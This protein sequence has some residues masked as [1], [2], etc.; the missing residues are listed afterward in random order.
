MSKAG[1]SQRLP[2][3]EPTPAT[4]EMSLPLL[5]EQNVDD[6]SKSCKWPDCNPLPGNT[7]VLDTMMS[8]SLVALDKRRGSSSDLP[9]KLRKLTTTDVTSSEQ[10]VEHPQKVSGD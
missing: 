6:S 10:G 5:A 9:R 8:V 1:V 3:A 7:D 2:A 4:I